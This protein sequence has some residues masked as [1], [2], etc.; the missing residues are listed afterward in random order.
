MECVIFGSPTLM[1]L[2]GAALLICIYDLVRRA[3]GYVFSVLAAAIFV[4]TTVYAFVL[5]A[6]YEEVGI[7]TL[8]FLALNLGGVMRSRGDRK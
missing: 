8:A 5:G 4:G 7:V 3:S 6:G 2:Y 1:L